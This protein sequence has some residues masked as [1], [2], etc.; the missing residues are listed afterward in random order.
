[1][2]MA[3]S[4]A[5]CTALGNAAGLTQRKHDYCF[6]FFSYGFSKLPDSHLLAATV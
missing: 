4:C 1:M 5:K 3:I 6:D 2:L